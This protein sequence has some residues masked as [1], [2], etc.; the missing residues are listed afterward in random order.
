M[1]VYIKLTKILNVYGFCSCVSIADFEVII[2]LRR[3]H[4]MYFH[5]FLMYVNPLTTNVCHDTETSQQLICIANQ[6]TG[7]YIW[8]TLV[9]D[10]LKT[11]I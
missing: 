11:N 3:L 6:L 10:G 1:W 5:D 7:F 2:A 8:G 4:L 9:I